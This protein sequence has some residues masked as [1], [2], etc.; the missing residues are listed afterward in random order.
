MAKA[1]AGDKLLTKLSNL[2]KSLSKD[3][4]E[5]LD[6][7]VLGNAAAF[8]EGA[9]VEGHMAISKHDAAS[10]AALTVVKGS[11]ARAAVE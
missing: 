4:R 5:I 9:E 6:A 3:Q 11:Y 1:T 10:A 2:R 8:A 7:I